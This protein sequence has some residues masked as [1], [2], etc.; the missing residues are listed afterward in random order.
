MDYVFH[1]YKGGDYKVHSER[2]KV[3]YENRTFIYAKK[4][5][6]DRLLCCEKDSIRKDTSSLNTAAR[7]L[8]EFVLDVSPGF[9][10]L[11]KNMRVLALKDFINNC[12]RKLVDLDNQKFKLLNEINGYTNELARLEP[13]K[14]AEVKE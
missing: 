4:H 10:E 14:K 13:D 3:V 11:Q 5:G 12:K 1:I 6:S 8:D 7:Y 2:L 9:T